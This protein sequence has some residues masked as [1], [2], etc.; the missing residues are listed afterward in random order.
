MLFLFAFSDS[1]SIQK[2]EKGKK[3]GKTG[4]IRVISICYR[5]ELVAELERFRNF[6]TS[7]PFCDLE[8]EQTDK[9]VRI[10]SHLES[11]CTL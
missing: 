9:V 6:G 5:T 3:E 4:I 11:L 1:H 7:M 10:L 2:K 8:I